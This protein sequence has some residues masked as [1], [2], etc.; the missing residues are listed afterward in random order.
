[1]Q[2]PLRPFLLKI[3]SFC[4][5]D[6]LASEFWIRQ[7]VPVTMLALKYT[8]YKFNSSLSDSAGN[9]RLWYKLLYDHL[10]MITY[11]LKLSFQQCPLPPSEINTVTL[12]LREHVITECTSA[13]TLSIRNARQ[14]VLVIPWFRLRDKV[15]K[16]TP[17]PI[18]TLTPMISLRLSLGFNPSSIVNELFTL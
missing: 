6:N 3:R 17:L 12:D 13:C 7:G 4:I 11:N 5:K 18:N 9:L 2:L 15:L 14:I 10:I 16:I 1:M 8:F